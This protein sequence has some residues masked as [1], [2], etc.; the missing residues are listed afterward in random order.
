L[1]FV[2]FFEAK[3]DMVEPTCVQL[4]KWEQAKKKVDV[5]QLDN[6]SDNVKL[7]KRAGS[8][9]WQ[10]GIKYEYTA[11]DTPQ[12]NHLAEVGLTVVANR[13]RALMVRAN[14]TY[15]SRYCLFRKAYKTAA[16]L[17]GFTVIEIAGKAD[18]CYVHWCGENPK[19]TNSLC[20][21]GEAGTVKIKTDKTPKLANRGVQFVFVGYAL[22][23]LGDTYRM[24]NPVADGVH[25]TRD[26][27]WLWQMYCEPVVLPSKKIVTRLP[28]T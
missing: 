12:Q 21:W 22:G 7:E 4:K 14:V 17:D 1:K 10:L 18:T 28:R 2:D 6:G 15:E 20:V 5:I 13:A 27:I 16:M 24:W 9:D 26:V 19:F 3:N 11:R 23:H 25:Q 8:K